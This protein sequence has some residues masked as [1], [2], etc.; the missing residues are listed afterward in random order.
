MSICRRFGCRVCLLQIPFL[1]CGSYV[2]QLDRY[3]MIF[4]IWCC[5]LV[6]WVGLVLEYGVCVSACACG[7]ERAKLQLTERER[8]T[9]NV[10]MASKHWSVK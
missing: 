9:E 1:V 8:E 4:L 2:D 3:V 6:G 10:C 7:V 5:C